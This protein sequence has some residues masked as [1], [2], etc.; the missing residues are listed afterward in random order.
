MIF[1]CQWISFAEN[2]DLAFDKDRIYA[3]F[4]VHVRALIANYV[5][6]KCLQGS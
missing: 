6:G 5:G 4:R 3:H 2:I 1:P